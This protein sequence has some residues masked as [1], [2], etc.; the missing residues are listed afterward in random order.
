MI[1]Y[2]KASTPPIFCLDIDRKATDCKKSHLKLCT[3]FRAQVWY[4]MENNIFW[5]AVAYSLGRILRTRP[6]I[7]T[8]GHLRSTPPPYQR[9]ILLILLIQ[10]LKGAKST[11]QIQNTGTSKKP[12]RVKTC[13]GYQIREV[14]IETRNRKISKISTKRSVICVC[15]LLP[16]NLAS[17]GF[18]MMAKQIRRSSACRKYPW[19]FIKRMLQWWFILSNGWAGE[20]SRTKRSKSWTFANLSF[21]STEHSFYQWFSSLSLS[22]G[23][24]FEA[25]SDLWRLF[26]MRCCCLGQWTKMLLSVCVCLPAGD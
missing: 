18:S 1:C 5:P 13:A 20:V 21:N 12:A 23:S 26:L 15:K 17:W 19:P 6:K 2:L 7:P 22:F 25:G 11:N 8:Q 24:V 10:D 3:N 4:C 14:I 16:R 9:V